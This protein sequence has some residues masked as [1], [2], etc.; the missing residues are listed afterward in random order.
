MKCAGNT[1]AVNNS[2]FYGNSGVLSVTP[3][4]STIPSRL[5]VKYLDCDVFAS[6]QVGGGGAGGPILMYLSSSASGNAPI[7]DL[8]IQ[9]GQWL[10][11]ASIYSGVNTPFYVGPRTWTAFA[12]NVGIRNV[13]IDNIRLGWGSTDGTFSAPIHYGAP[14][15]ELSY[16]GDAQSWAAF[17][18]YA[19]IINISRITFGGGT[20]DGDR[21]EFAFIGIN[22]CEVDDVQ[23]DGDWTRTGLGSFPTGRFMLYPTVDYL[24]KNVARYS[25]IKYGNM[26]TGYPASNSSGGIFAEA[27]FPDVSAHPQGWKLSDSCGIL[28]GNAPSGNGVAIGTDNSLISRVIERCSLFG[29]LNI[30]TSGNGVWCTRLSGNVNLIVRDCRISSWIE[31]GIIVATTTWA[32][33]CELSNNYIDGCSQPG[34][35]IAS[36]NW[37]GIGPRIIGNRIIGCDRGSYPPH[38]YSQIRIGNPGIP[39][40]CATVIG[41]DCDVQGAGGIEV[42]SSGLMYVAGMDMFSYDTNVPVLVSSTPLSGTQ[43]RQNSAV[44]RSGLH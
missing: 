20:L 19:Q 41:N 34:I 11:E 28:P 13:V 27:T 18:V 24:T 36:N 12:E 14:A 30:A 31:S 15:T 26:L 29:S 42:L 43:L 2:S 40:P 5:N 37:V 17:T 7:V 38:L 39:N 21:A 25:T 22:S 16:G 9:G 1:V 33:A 10:A 23:C 32:G 44:W 4:T 35:L 3:A 8:T 6:A